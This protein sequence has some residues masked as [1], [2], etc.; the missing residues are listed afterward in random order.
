MKTNFLFIQIAFDL[1]EDK[2]IV[3]DTFISLLSEIEA[4]QGK[5]SVLTDT[6]SSN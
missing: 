6:I 3:S 5:S 1:G 4:L 2:Q